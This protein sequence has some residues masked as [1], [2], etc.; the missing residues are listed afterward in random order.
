MLVFYVPFPDEDTARRISLEVVQRRLAACAQIFPIQSV[1]P[2]QGSI[3]QEGEWVVLFKTL[4]VQEAAL[5]AAL[6]ALHP[7]E[8]PCLMRAEVGVNA[9]YGQWLGEVLGVD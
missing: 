3:Q 8:V 7:Y 5:E 4:R 1:Y 9:A 6:E 2:W